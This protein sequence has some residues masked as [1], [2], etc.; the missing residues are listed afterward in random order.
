MAN[1]KALGL[2]GFPYEFYKATLDFIGLNL[3]QVYKEALGYGSLGAEINQG[4]IKF[5][6]KARDPKL[7]TIRD[8]SLYSIRINLIK[9]WPRLWLYASNIFFQ[10]L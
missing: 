2:N 6:P 8:P 5:I 4:L 3:L 9:L 7:I 10:R 1:G